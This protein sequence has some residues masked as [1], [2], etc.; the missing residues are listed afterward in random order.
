MKGGR[1]EDCRDEER[2]L[3][4]NSDLARN[5]CLNLEPVRPPLIKKLVGQL[6]R[7]DP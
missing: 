4:V 5:K 6:P 2:F 3:H 1:Q 7:S